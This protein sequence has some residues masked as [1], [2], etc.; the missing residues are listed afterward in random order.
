MQSH[1]RDGWYGDDAYHAW[2]QAGK[3]LGP[4]LGGSGGAA[5]GGDDL[6]EEQR[7]HAAQVR[8]GPGKTAADWIPSDTCRPS[9][10]AGLIQK[11]AGEANDMIKNM[12]GLSG[13]LADLVVKN[14]S[15]AWIPNPAHVDNPDTLVNSHTRD[16]SDLIGV[17]KAICDLTGLSIEVVGSADIVSEGGTEH[18]DSHRDRDLAPASMAGDDDLDGLIARRPRRTPAR[19]CPG[20]AILIPAESAREYCEMCD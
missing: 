20:C 12:E 3:P 6:T 14:E 18:S 9:N 5:E 15:G 11:V 1:L 2:I 4:G 19:H 7:Q 13:T 17:P 8:F 16:M 10:V